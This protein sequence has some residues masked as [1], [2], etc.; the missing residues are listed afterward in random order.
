[1]SADLVSVST[2]ATHTPNR[3]EPM[4]LI[5]NSWTRWTAVLLA[6]GFLLLAAW[7]GLSAYRGLVREGKPVS[8]QTLAMAAKQ[9]RKQMEEAAKREKEKLE[10]EMKSEKHDSLAKHEH[11]HEHK[12]KKHDDH[13]EKA[14]EYRAVSGAP[15]GTI[16]LAD[17]YGVYRWTAEGRVS[18]PAHPGKDPHCLLA[19]LGVLWL[20]DKE[21]LHRLDES[22]DRWTTVYR[23]EVKGVSRAAD[24]SLVLATKK[25]GVLQSS[26]GEGWAALELAAAV[27]PAA[28]AA[29]APD[30][31]SSGTGDPSDAGGEVATAP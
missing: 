20:G 16:Y 22:G 23:G 28:P 21:G 4:K 1:M 25:D 29:A 2:I 14:P 3:S 10:K 18:L 17:K 13:G 6:V 27:D 30:G 8:A 31:P 11:K 26:D 24:G 12:D 9:E 7:P 15:D 5:L 19:E